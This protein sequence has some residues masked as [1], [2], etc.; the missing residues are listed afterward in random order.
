MNTEP[1]RACPRCGQ[2]LSGA[3]EFCPV[4]MFRKAFAGS[5]VPSEGSSVEA[6]L[7]TTPAHAAQRFGHY[8]LVRGQDGTPVELGVIGQR[9]IT[10]LIFAIKGLQDDARP[11][12]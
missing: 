8:E 7:E 2:E 5:R 12:N 3:L 6:T 10:T 11:E 1:R 9:R 4:C